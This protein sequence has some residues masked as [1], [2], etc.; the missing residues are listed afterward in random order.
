MTRVIHVQAGQKD[1]NTNSLCFYWYLLR[2]SRQLLCFMIRFCICTNMLWQNHL[3][4]PLLRKVVKK[5]KKT[6]TE[7]KGELLVLCEM[8]GRKMQGGRWDL[9][10]DLKILSKLNS[11]NT[12]RPLHKYLLRLCCVEGIKLEGTDPALK[13]PVAEKDPDRGWDALGR[14]VRAE[15]AKVLRAQPPTRPGGQWPEEDF[16]R[17]WSLSQI[18]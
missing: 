16:Q 10:W 14:A 2:G 4:R 9:Q 8:Q 17:R 12:I 5:I 15:G 3:T 11:Q 1:L 6:L 7:Y 18:F 13:D